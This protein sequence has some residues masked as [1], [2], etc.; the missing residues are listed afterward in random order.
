MADM[1][2]AAPSGDTSCLRGNPGGELS[3]AQGPGSR[4]AQ[5]LGRGQEVR[6]APG[7]GPQVARSSECRRQRQH[8]GSRGGLVPASAPICVAP[9]DPEP[10]GRCCRALA[11]P[12]CLQ[13][14]PLFSGP[15]LVCPRLPGEDGAAAGRLP[16]SLQ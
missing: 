14:E 3:G 1:G 5:A 10:R 9:G 13:L 2:L 12:P 11:H 8:R 16:T 7:T 15:R 6:L 4:S